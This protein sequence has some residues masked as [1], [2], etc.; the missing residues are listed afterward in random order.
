MLDTITV[1]SVYK[2][3][4]IVH[5]WQY[6]YVLSLNALKSWALNDRIDD[7]KVMNLNE[8]QKENGK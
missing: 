3:L 7:A 1:V 5:V 2:Y 8:K 4:T 6:F